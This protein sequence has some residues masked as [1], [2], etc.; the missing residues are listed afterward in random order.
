MVNG[1]T[2]HQAYQTFIAKYE[3]SLL[4]Y[5]TKHWLLPTRC[6]LC[7]KVSSAEYISS[8]ITVADHMHM[9]SKNIT[10]HCPHF[11]YEL[12]YFPQY[13]YGDPC[14]IVLIG[15]WDCW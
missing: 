10:I 1:L 14:N 6:T 7:N 2:E 15:Y 12:S 13:A 8:F 9:Q 5:P 3:L 11:H 4:C